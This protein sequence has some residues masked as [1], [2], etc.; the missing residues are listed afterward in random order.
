MRG[1]NVG[2]SGRNLRQNYV[3]QY[4]KQFLR[5]V[6]P[7]LFQNHPKE[8]LR[9][10][11]SLQDLL[12]LVNHEKDSHMDRRPPP[13]DSSVGSKPTKLVFYFKPNDPPIPPRLTLTDALK[14]TTHS[15]SQLESVEHILPMFEPKSIST[16]TGDTARQ[17]ALEQ[18]LKSWQMVQ[19]FLELCRKVGVSVKDSDQKDVALQLELSTQEITS[20]KS[21]NPQAP[22]KSLS[23]IFQ[24]EL[25]TSFSGSIGHQKPTP[26]WT[27]ASTGNETNIEGISQTYLGKIG[28]VA[29]ALDAQVMIK[30]NPLLFKSSELSSSRLSR[31]IRTWIHWQDEDQ[32]LVTS[33]NTSIQSATPFRL[34]EWWRKVPIMILSS[35]KEREEVL[36]SPGNNQKGMLIVDQEMSKQEMIEYLKNNLERIQAEYKDMLKSTL[37]TPTSG[38]S[39]SALRKKQQEQQQVAQGHQPGWSPSPD[40]ASYLERMRIKAQLQKARGGSRGRGGGG[41]VQGTRPVF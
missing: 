2:K 7:D 30:S 39:P 41:G 40:A 9:N 37:M 35:M 23:E 20:K 36:S 1:H 11:T 3:Q 33:S 17:S 14:T 22:Q 32:H 8:Q 27:G 10:S 25:Q 34:G 12:P 16:E 26:T 28:G 21:M 29:P 6:H 19:S 5:R 24:E 31:V 13:S 18:E 15:Q 38:G 4:L